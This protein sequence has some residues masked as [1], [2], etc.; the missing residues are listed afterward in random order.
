M[1]L[2]YS[3]LVEENHTHVAQ[4]VEGEKGEQ[5]NRSPDEGAGAL[6]KENL[7]QILKIEN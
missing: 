4:V 7:E 1:S 3:A 5:E 2:P 6:E